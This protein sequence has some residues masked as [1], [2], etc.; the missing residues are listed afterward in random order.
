[1]ENRLANSRSVFLFLALTWTACV[2]LTNAQIPLLQHKASL[3][4]WFTL[5]PSNA[6]PSG[7]LPT[8]KFCVNHCNHDA[9]C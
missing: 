6:T 8:G 2:P 1:M 4:Q 7:R 9:L 5:V 3:L